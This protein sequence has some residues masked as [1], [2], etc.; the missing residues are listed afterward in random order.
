MRI[1]RSMLGFLY[2]PLLI[3]SVVLCAV[4]IASGVWYH[5]DA[6]AHASLALIV[7]VVLATMAA[8]ENGPVGMYVIISW[9]LALVVLFLTW[10]LVLA[11]TA[12]GTAAWQ[13]FWSSLLGAPRK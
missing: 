1:L 7:V 9:V 12:E 2:F 13:G 3:L 4:T 10:L 11:F 8:K 5:L 6:L